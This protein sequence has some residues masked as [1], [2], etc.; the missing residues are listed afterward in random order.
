[1][2]KRVK[3]NHKLYNKLAKVIHAQLCEDDGWCNYGQPVPEELR[4]D[5]S[6]PVEKRQELAGKRLEWYQHCQYAVDAENIAARVTFARGSK[7]R[8]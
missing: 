4:Y 7:V 5:E 6:H 2:A 8:K 3:F 1:V